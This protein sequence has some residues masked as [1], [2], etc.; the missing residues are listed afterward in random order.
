[1]EHNFADGTNGKFNGKAFI[2]FSDMRGAD[3]L[4]DHWKLQNPIIQWFRSKF[5]FLCG[6]SP[7]MHKGQY[8][9][10]SRPAEPTD[11]LWE[12]LV[13]SDLNKTIRRLCLGLL[14][15]V[16]MGLCWYAIYWMM[17]Y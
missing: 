11:Y 3:Y 6:S 10:I 1:M 12:N 17:A 16:F 8:V 14:T 9:D 5:P 2:T 13:Y 7:Y 15:V 4:T